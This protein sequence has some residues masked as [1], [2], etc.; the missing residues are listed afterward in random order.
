MKRQGKE[1][2]KAPE[3]PPVLSC[4]L[5]QDSITSLWLG[6]CL[7][8]NIV[9]SAKSPDTAW[10][11]LRA[12]IKLHV[13]QCFAHHHEGLRRR[14]PEEDWAL[15]NELKNQQEHFRSEPINLKLVSPEKPPEIWALCVESTVQIWSSGGKEQ[16][17]AATAAIPGVH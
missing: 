11:N 6:Q 12:V 10:K 7:D 2:E 3:I 4:L 9:T 8:F 1:S 16:G 14:A 5:T 15:F 17:S 13:E